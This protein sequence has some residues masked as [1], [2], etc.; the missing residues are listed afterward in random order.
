MRTLIA[1]L[2]L[3]ALSMPSIAEDDVFVDGYTRRDGTYVEPYHRTA[4]DDTKTNNY[5]YE[6]N[7]NPYNGRVGT[8]EPGVESLFEGGADRRSNESVGYR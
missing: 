3:L 4:P 1:A 8:R 5:S 7:E 2:S 6:G